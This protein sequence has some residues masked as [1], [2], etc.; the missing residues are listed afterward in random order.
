MEKTLNIRYREYA[1][2][3]ALGAA[4]GELM[5]RAVAATEGA[6]APYSGFRVGAAVRLADG[7]ERRVQSGEVRVKPL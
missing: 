5:R 1:S 2:A 4:D 3:A 7:S 6:Y